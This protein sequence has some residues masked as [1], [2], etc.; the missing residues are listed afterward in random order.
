MHHPERSVYAYYKS[1]AVYLQWMETMVCFAIPPKTL[2]M[3]EA[4][5]TIE[6]IDNVMLFE[7]ESQMLDAFLDVIQDA[8]VLSGWNSEGF[9]IPYTVNRI[10]KTLSKEDTKRLCLWGSAILKNVSMKSLAKTSETYDLVGRVHV[11]SA[12]TCIESTT[13]EERH[14]YR[15][16]AIGE[17]EVGETKTV[18]EGSLDALYNNDFRTVY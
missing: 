2:T 8:D 16:D 1:I 14:T 11:D 5:K 9:D 18:Y 4:K 15:L 17:L 6:G 12:R 7:K 13:Y 3:E 10:T